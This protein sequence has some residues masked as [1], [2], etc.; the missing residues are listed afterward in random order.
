MT[1]NQ[2]PQRFSSQLFTAAVLFFKSTKLLFSKS[3][4][5]AMSL[6][7]K[8]RN[9]RPGK[10]KQRQTQIVSNNGNIGYGFNQNVAMANE[11]D[12]QKSHS[13]KGDICIS[14]IYYYS[15]ITHIRIC[16]NML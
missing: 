5:L 10:R 2:D 14:N 7:K 3:T 8:L 11:N 6:P 15:F 16:C 4:K 12:D 1:Q 9:N 13:D